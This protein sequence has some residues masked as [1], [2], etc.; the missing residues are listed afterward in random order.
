MRSICRFD[1]HVRDLCR[2][3][4]GN[5]TSAVRRR[6]SGDV[7]QQRWPEP[8]PSVGRDHIDGGGSGDPAGNGQNTN[9]LMG[10]IVRLDIDGG[11]PY[12]IPAGNRFESNP[13][14]TGGTGTS[15]C[16]EIYAW[17]LRNPWRFSFD[18]LTSKLWAGDV[19]QGEW[20]EVDVITAGGNY[21]WN[22]REGAHCFNPS[23]GCENT[24][25]EP[26]SEYDHGLGRSITGGFVYRGSA[27]A[28]LA[29]WYVFGDF[30]S[31]RLFGIPEDSEV[32][33]TPEIFGQTGLQIVSFGQ[34]ANGELYVLYFGGTIHQIADAP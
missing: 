20:E 16:P 13:V 27:I 12:G 18:R 7:R 21:G 34:D 15:P 19:G 17:G 1:R 23:V 10:A 22:V 6:R 3:S 5:S 33:E 4:T 32:G 11:S 8:Q 30:V 2:K 9:T 26:I 28:N 25:I 29:G 14:C 24:F 31:G